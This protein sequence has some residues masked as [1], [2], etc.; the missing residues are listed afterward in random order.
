MEGAQRVDRST[1]GPGGST[2]ICGSDVSW[3]LSCGISYPCVFSF[4]RGVRQLDPVYFAFPLCRSYPGTNP[5]V[6]EGY[7]VLYSG[8]KSVVCLTSGRKVYP[9]CILKRKGGEDE[10]TLTVCWQECWVTLSVIPFSLCL[11][12][13]GLIQPILHSLI[14]SLPHLTPTWSKIFEG[15]KTDWL[16][17]L[18]LLDYL[19]HSSQTQV[20]HGKEYNQ[21]RLCMWA[22]MA[23]SSLGQLNN[24]RR[25]IIT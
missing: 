9:I 4:R 18:C 19:L 10:M 6:L 21:P 2:S 23:C 15:G 1:R 5:V 7:L 25:V 12:F 16:R 14:F 20:I 24:R 8:K 22:A 11:F 3:R 13:L 17:R